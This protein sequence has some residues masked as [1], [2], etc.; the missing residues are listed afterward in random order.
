MKRNEHAPPPWSVSIED[1]TVIIRDQKSSNHARRIGYSFT[2]AA[3]RPPFFQT[4][5]DIFMSKLEA[6]SPLKLVQSEQTNDQPGGH[7]KEI[8]AERFLLVDTEGNERAR[9]EV[10]NEDTVLALRDRRGKL[11]LTLR[12]GEREAQLAVFDEHKGKDPY[13]VCVAELGYH[14]VIG[15]T[16][17]SRLTLNDGDEATRVMLTV[18]SQGDGAATVYDHRNNRSILNG[19]VI[20]QHNRRGGRANQIVSA[21]RKKAIDR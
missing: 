8:R 11:R 3:M 1:F 10:I 12:A 16:A 7:Q 21:R 14:H 15:R 5:E 13:C 9:L 20:T 19:N 17:P 18:N 2:G 6:K 4:N